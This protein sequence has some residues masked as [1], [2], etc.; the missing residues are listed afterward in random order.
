MLYTL[1]DFSKIRQAQESVIAAHERFSH[2]LKSMHDAII[3]VDPQSNVL[4]FSNI[5]Y[6]SLFGETSQGHF[7][8]HM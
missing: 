5:V 6:D 3:V 2:F 1:T 8:A 7:Q 4:L